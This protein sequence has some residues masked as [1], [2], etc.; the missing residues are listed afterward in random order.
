[1][2][3]HDA[4]GRELFVC[5]E[6]KCRRVEAEFEVDRHGNRRRGCILCKTRRE[7]R[8]CEHGRQRKECCECDPAGNERRRHIRNARE[9]AMQSGGWP[10]I[11][12][13]NGSKQFYDTIVNKWLSVFSKMVADG[14][15]DHDYHRKI[16]ANLQPWG[17]VT[18]TDGL[19]NEE[20]DK[21]LRPIYAEMDAQK[22]RREIQETSYESNSCDCFF[23]N[24]WHKDPIGYN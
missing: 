15:I 7:A 1:M 21:I 4:Q 20:L 13:R 14:F 11:H 17:P 6:C 8:K 3:T 5:S 9:F 24:C 10:Y 22:P 18:K 16:L 23:S 12:I 19:T 2:A